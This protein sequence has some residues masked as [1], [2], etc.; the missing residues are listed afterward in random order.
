MSCLSVAGNV[1]DPEGALDA[2]M[3]VNTFALFGIILSFAFGLMTFAFMPFFYSGIV[4]F[5]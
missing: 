4:L 5:V 1:D 3:Q 2:L